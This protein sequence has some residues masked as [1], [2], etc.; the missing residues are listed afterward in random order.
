MCLGSDHAE[1]ES[2]P[3]LPRPS[4]HARSKEGVFII[5]HMLYASVH[6][7]LEL[8]HT[9]YTS[10]ALRGKLYGVGAL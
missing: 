6:Y 9:V 5:H 2:R 3:L 7:H 4:R 1:F 8:S 10:N